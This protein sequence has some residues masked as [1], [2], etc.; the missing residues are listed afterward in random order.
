M[1]ELHAVG[2][3]DRERTVTVECPRC[4]RSVDVPAQ[5]RTG[6]PTV[7]PYVAAFGDPTVGRCEGG[8]R[9]WVYYC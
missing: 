4:D 1:T 9:F 6:E 2:S 7:S 5:D 8:H 3:E